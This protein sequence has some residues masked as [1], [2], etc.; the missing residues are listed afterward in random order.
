MKY[1]TLL[2]FIAIGAFSYGQQ[3]IVTPDGLR[4]AEDIEKTYVVI[5]AEGKTANQL[6]DNALKFINKNYKS[7]DDVIKG[8]IQGE[9]L[10][11]ITHVPDFLVVNNSGA[12]IL[13]DADY[14]IELNFKDG[15]AKYEIIFLDMYWQNGPYKVLFTGGALEGYIIYN[16]KGELKRPETKTDIENFFNA[17]I[18]SITEFLSGK[19]EKDE[20]I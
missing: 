14:T 6:Y 12:K 10:K 8:N 19:S 17:Q 2:F 1:F 13:I 18:E 9:Y 4:D 15:K 11:F 5:N 16:K 3:L 7:P 20:W